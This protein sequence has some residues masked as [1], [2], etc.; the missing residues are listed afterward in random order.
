MPGL[1]AATRS[2]KVAS[3]GLSGNLDETVIHLLKMQRPRFSNRA[4]RG[5]RVRLA[6]N[7]EASLAGNCRDRRGS[8]MTDSRPNRR[9]SSTPPARRW[10]PSRAR[11][12]WSASVAGRA[13]GALRPLA[14]GG[15]ESGS[16]RHQRQGLHDGPARAAGRGVCGVGRA[17]RRRR[18]D[19]R[20]Q[21]PRRQ[22]H[23]DL[24]CEGHDGRARLHRLPQPRRRRRRC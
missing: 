13:S 9:H 21:E 14:P 3:R 20:H 11:R 17:L 5:S 10:P 23:A 6:A 24:R 16:H 8:A 15:H 18:L 7:P 4:K 12:N 22:E 2:P 1:D 19:Q